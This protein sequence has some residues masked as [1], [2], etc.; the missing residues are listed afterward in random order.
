MA[1]NPRRTAAGGL[2]LLLLVLYPFAIGGIA[3]RVVASKASARLG[4][5]VTVGRGRGGLGTIVL[6]DVVIG[7]DGSGPALARIDR[8]TVPLGI[9]LGMHSAVEVAGLRVEAVR[10][11]A[12]D[13]LSAMLA[14]VRGQHH[15]DAG[16]A[17]PEAGGAKPEGGGRG[18]TKLPDIVITSGTIKARDEASRLA[19]Y[20]GSFDGELR[21]DSRLAFH[22]RNTRAVLAF[23]DA[24][25]GPRFGADELDVQTPL[26]G[27]RPS[28]VPSLR[29]KGGE[30]SPL[31][32]LALTGIAGIIAPP[33]AGANPQ[34][35]DALKSLVIDLR[36]SYGGARETLWTAKGHAEPDKAT[37]TLALRAEQFSL[38]RIGDVLP[39]S[40][41]R[42]ENTT[43][44][45]ALDLAWAGDAVRFAG[46]LAVVGLSLQHD[47]IALEPV[48]NV[49]VGL[50]LRGTAHPLARVLEVERAEARVRDLTARLSGTVAMPAGT[51]KFA[52]GRKLDVVPKI[53][54][55]LTVPRVSCAKMLTSIPPALIPRLQGFVLQGMFGA[56]VGIKVDFAHLDQLDLTGKIAIDGCKVLKAPPEVTALAG[57]ESLVVNVEAPK[58]PGAPAGSEPD[59][60]SVVVGPDNPDFAPY[61][62]ISPYLVGSIMT[63]ED[64]GFFKHRGWVSSEFKSALRRNLERGGFRL[65]ASSIT[66]QMVK[67]VLLTKD[68]TLSRKAQELF[69]VW[70]LEQVLP[71]ERILELYFN[72]I[73]FGPR[74]YGIGAASRH[75]FGKKPSELT[76]LEGAFISSILPSPKRR[77]IQYCHGALLP[78][79]DRYVHRILAKVHERGRLTDDEY[80]SWSVQSL[81][82][83]RKEATF[84][85]K[86]CLDWV[87]SMVPAK[88]DVES[89][90]DIEDADGD[91]TAEKGGGWPPKRLKRLFTHASASPPQHHVGPLGKSVAKSVV[92]SAQ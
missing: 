55:A 75:Y 27:L 81:A 29:V 3:A 6:D 48:E 47:S 22:L 82:F 34:G 78:Q 7:D 88:Q 12:E 31:P 30:A 70:Y 57:E 60:L 58:P 38:A 40:V 65:G 19:L 2:A 16:G 79:W 13:N 8:I 66:M 91:A 49:S 21:P 54:L 61:E 73:E 9:L 23:G 50:T 39:S 51:F 44:D 14:H 5:P 62:Q 4:T 46:E 64:N 71:K 63:T 76:P 72:A 86:Q 42:P 80:Q 37:G 26:T 41:L 53:D 25:Q 67:N 89:T 36:G 59:V 85:E 20:V 35:S 87:K 84:T 74:I 33:P 52:N 83:D 10:G 92:T 69:L 18:G 45:A 11:G 24:G 32:S 68:K 56:D 77:Y 1:A 90:P 28:G 17:K 15:A 43:L